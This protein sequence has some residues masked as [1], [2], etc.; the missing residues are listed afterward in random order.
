MRK[1]NPEG[2]SEVFKETV[3]ISVTEPSRH[4]EQNE[5]RAYFHGISDSY[6]SNLATM[7]GSVQAAQLDV[8]DALKE[9]WK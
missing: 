8:R 1:K 6:F 2:L 3:H 5:E 9:A 4:W 7:L